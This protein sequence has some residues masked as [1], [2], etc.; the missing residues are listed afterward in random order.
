VKKYL[1]RF[2]KRRDA[3]EPEIVKAFEDC[4][5]SVERI[6]KPCDL[7]VGK[8]GKSFLIEVKTLTGKLNDKQKEFVEKWKGN[9]HIIRTIEDVIKFNEVQNVIN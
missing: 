2:A 3:N 7:I 6:D 1:N 8:W 9:Y 4:G 5:Y